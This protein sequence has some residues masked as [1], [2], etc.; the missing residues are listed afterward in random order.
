MPNLRFC[1]KVDKGNQTRQPYQNAS[2]EKAAAKRHRGDYFCTVT[3]SNPRIPN[4]KPWI[5][6][7]TKEIFVFTVKFGEPAM[8]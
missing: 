7:S 8:A 3:V 6:P 5:N 4:V 2:Y 1:E